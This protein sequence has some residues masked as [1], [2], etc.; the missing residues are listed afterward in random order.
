MAITGLEEKLAVLAEHSLLKHVD[1]SELS[2]LAAYS[3]V[4]RH[5]PR[6]TIFRQ[7][8]P[9]SS[10][11]AVLSGRVR[12]CSYSPEGKEVTLNIVR[13]GEFF[14]EIALLDGKPRTAEA[15]AI[16]ETDLL[17]LERRHFMPWLENHPKVCVRMFGVLCDRLRRTSTQLEDTLFLEVPTRL[18]RCLVRLATA[19]GV[20]ERGGGTRIDVK[21]SQQQLGTLVGITRES[22][23]KHLNEWQRDGLITVGAGT[24]TIRDLEGLRELADF[25]DE[26]DA[27]A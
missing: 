24:V 1:P 27:E 7:G 3:T 9:G 14:G 12:I 17:V 20:Q 25:F 6:A 5:R 19:F 22:T 8:D 10:M 2:Q 18:A 23:N 13:K 21:L 11:M 16:E 15:L 26:E 4:A